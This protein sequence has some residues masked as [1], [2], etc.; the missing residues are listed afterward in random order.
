MTSD[1]GPQR[2]NSDM[3]QVLEASIKAG[4]TLV[5][6]CSVPGQDMPH[7]GLADWCGTVNDVVVSGLGALGA[8][9]LQAGSPFSLEL[10][11]GL[12]LEQARAVAWLRGR[13]EL[14]QEVGAAHLPGDDV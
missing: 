1:S 5:E 11:D 7:R 2:A 12:T 10:K 14:L 8:D 13:I 3:R 9:L 6:A 4:E